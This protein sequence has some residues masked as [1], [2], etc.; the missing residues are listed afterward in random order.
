[1]PKM[2]TVSKSERGETSHRKHLY[3]DVSVYSW[4]GIHALLKTCGSSFQYALSICMH[5]AVH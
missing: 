1:M 2:G 5:A 4:S 3:N